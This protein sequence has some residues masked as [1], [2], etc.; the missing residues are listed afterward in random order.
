MLKKLYFQ[1]GRVK[2][3]WYF[4]AI[5]TAPLILIIFSLY[6]KKSSGPHWLGGNSDPSYA[7]LLNGLNAIQLKDIGHFDHPGTPVQVLSGAIARSLSFIRHLSDKDFVSHVL[8]D[9]EYYLNAINYVFLIAICVLLV[10]VG[11]CI[12]KKTKSV[13]LSLLTQSGVFFSSV[14]F[15]YLNAIAPEPLL[16]FSDLLITLIVVK[17]V[18]DKKPN[19]N[20]YGLEFALVA[21]FGIATK[22]TFL[23]LLILPLVV[24]PKIKDKILFMIG[25]ILA[26]IF[27]TL[28]IRHHYREFFDWVYRLFFNSGI[29]GTGPATVVDLSAYLGNIKMLLI[30][31]YPFF[32]LLLLDSLILLAVILVKRKNSEKTFP[33]QTK[34]LL[35]LTL[36]I[37]VGILEVAKHPGQHYFIP[38][39]GTAGLLVFLFIQNL[40]AIKK[41]NSGFYSVFVV[42]LIISIIGSLVSTLHQTRFASLSLISQKNKIASVNQL[43]DGRYKDFIKVDYYRSSSVASALEFGNMFSS[44]INAPELKKLYPTAYN[45]NIWRQKYY[46][47]GDEITFDDLLAKSKGAIIFQGPPFEGGY[48]KDN[49]EYRPKVPLIDKINGDIETIYQYSN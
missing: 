44:N 1:L 37:I 4:L 9:P 14:T 25:L 20:K 16:I 18:F 26:F 5:L 39:I 47:W 22:I 21:G 28:P 6:I 31:I 8:A 34:I 32:G 24:L 40:P 3:R 10:V 42:M 48:Y 33:I 11:W 45:F 2:P 29:Y 17:L 7:Y 19:W 15:G 46:F 12:Y 41:I 23:P 38:F 13:M 30:T 43:R 36:S 49:P 27:F 35:G